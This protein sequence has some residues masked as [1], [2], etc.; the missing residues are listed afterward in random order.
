MH[1][2]P[3][4]TPFTTTA[5]RSGVHP[6]AEYARMAHEA[7][8]LLG[9]PDA[10]VQ[11]EPTLPDDDSAP[12]AVQVRIYPMGV[13]IRHG[14]A[15]P[16]ADGRAA[17]SNPESAWPTIMASAAL[18][19][20]RALIKGGLVC[21]GA[22]T[23]A[24]ACVSRVPGVRSRLARMSSGSRLALGVALDAVII[25]GTAQLLLRHSMV[26]ADNLVVDALARSNLDGPL[27][28]Y[29]ART[30]AN[31]VSFDMPLQIVPG[32]TGADR[33]ERMR[34]RLKQKWGLSAYELVDKAAGKLVE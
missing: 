3:E 32:H 25:T 13:V 17:P 4:R 24:T 5:M 20:D 28:V 22:A 34:K 7:L 2:Q 27:G 12:C 31:N 8:S 26:H 6:P 19:A 16:M 33:F 11:L 29:L 15:A 23:L 9:H 18:S 14:R 10:D 1:R 30:M 21:L